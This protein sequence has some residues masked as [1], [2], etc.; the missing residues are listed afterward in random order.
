M[1]EIEHFPLNLLPPSALQL[2]LARAAIQMVHG[3]S[4][5]IDKLNPVHD[6]VIPLSGCG[7]YRIGETQ[8]TLAPGEAMLIPA[9]QRF[10]GRHGGG[11]ETYTGIAQHFSLD[12]FGKGDLISQMRLRQKVTL[13]R[14]DLLE[15]LVR[16]YR[17]TA[18]QGATTLP[19][20]HQFMVILLAFLQDAF[21]DWGSMDA[22]VPKQDQLSL[23]IMFV[24]SRLSA[25]P[26][27]RGIEE[28][29][30]SVPYNPD[31]FRRAFSEKIGMTPQKFRDLKRMEFAISRLDAG[32]SVKQVAAELGYSDPYFFSRIFK[33]HIGAPPSS[34]HPRAGAAVGE[35]GSAG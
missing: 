1:D 24:T 20:H 15:P 25:D 4:W 6:L 18:P 23:H 11:D 29:L 32:L 27:G 8:I 22:A 12:L 35:E 34:Y 5:R 33:R 28:A 31:Y 10:H 30:E 16:L 13:S 26:L 7:H 21:L 19:Q 3:K 2:R 17:E 9:F 14:W